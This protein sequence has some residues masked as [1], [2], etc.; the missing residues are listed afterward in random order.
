[1]STYTYV[2]QFLVHPGREAEFERHYG[3]E[4]AWVQLF[5]RA[6]GYLD[7][8]LLRDRATPGRYVTIDRWQDEAAYRGFRA[9]F[10]AE[11]D[12]VDRE[13]EA[14]TREERALGEYD[15]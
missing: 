6:D 7:T 10:A 15:E 2:W 3:P 13:C 1:M 4:G 8:R 11:H 9:C 12:A 14:L 5:R